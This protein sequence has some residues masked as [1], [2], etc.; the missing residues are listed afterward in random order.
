MPCN[1]HAKF[2]AKRSPILIFKPGLKTALP[3]LDARALGPGGFVTIS[4]RDCGMSPVA[5]SLT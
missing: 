4:V 1:A 3:R 5:G 2:R